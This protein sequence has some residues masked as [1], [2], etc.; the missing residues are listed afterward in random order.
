MNWGAWVQGL[1]SAVANG[2]VTALGASAVIPGKTTLSELVT[3]AAI[4]T[5]ISFFMYLK[6]SPPPLTG[7]K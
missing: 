5:I 4:P 3:I 6:Q 1:I 7:L 2:I